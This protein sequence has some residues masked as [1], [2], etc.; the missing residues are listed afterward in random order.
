MLGALF[1]LGGVQ[2]GG[3]VYLEAGYPLHR[4]NRE[5]DKKKSGKTQG[6]WKFC[7]NTGILVCSSCRTNLQFLFGSWIS[8]PSLFCVYVIVTNHVSWHRENL[9]LDRDTRGI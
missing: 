9:P 7:Q 3:G 2:K 8:L 5:N 6:I 4:E 1:G